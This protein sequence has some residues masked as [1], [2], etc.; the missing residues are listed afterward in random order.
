LAGGL[1]LYGY[2]AG[3]PLNNSD[4]FGLCPVATFICLKAG[5]AF[6][7]AFPRGA[8]VLANGVGTAMSVRSLSAEATNEARRAVESGDVPG[9]GLPGGGLHNGP[10]D[11]VRHA[12]W[13]CK[14]TRRHGAA[15]AAAAGNAHE[16]AGQNP[17]AE[18]QMDQ[19]NNAAGRAL[20]SEE[21]D[22]TALAAQASNAGRLQ[23]TPQGGTTP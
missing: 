20:A 23:N 12:S 10:G 9:A 5:L 17:T 6:A 8:F 13:Q 4:P 19:A 3:D 1:N 18:R 22:C 15:V 21:G 11:A 2:G 16:D 14:V 7:G